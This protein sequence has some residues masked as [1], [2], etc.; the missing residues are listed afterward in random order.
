MYVERKGRKCCVTSP[1][2][3]ADARDIF[4]NL[5]A[6]SLVTYLEPY[7]GV[8]CHRSS[9]ACVH[10]SVVSSLSLCIKNLVFRNLKASET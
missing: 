3:P 5:I 2:C 4:Y 7:P 9:S 6:I 8:F 1:S 10:L